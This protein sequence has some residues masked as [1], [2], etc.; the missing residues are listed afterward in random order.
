MTATSLK[1]WGEHSLS[2]GEQRFWQLGPLHF[3]LQR[4]RQDWRLQHWRSR[5]SESDTV[6]LAKD[7]APEPYPEGCSTLRLQFADSPTRLTLKPRLADKPFVVKPDAPLRLAGGER[8]TFYMTTI[9]RLEIHHQDKLLLEIP[10][11]DQQ[12]TWFGDFTRGELCYASTTMARPV[13]ED[14]PVRAYRPVTPVT[15]SNRCSETMS[16]DQF[17][18]P[19]NLLALY[20]N[21]NGR[22]F[23]DGLDITCRNNGE[24][25]DVTVLR[26]GNKRLTVTEKIADARESTDLRQRFEAERFFRK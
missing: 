17:K 4:N 14:V 19:V 11:F 18:M 26:G 13:F 5:E 22:L 6:L 24:E 23:T 20:A 15:I 8:T 1:W 21:D 2:L 16:L 12:E 7:A 3:S 9:M 25:V 10:G